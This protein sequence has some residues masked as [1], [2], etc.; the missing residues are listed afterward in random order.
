M[1]DI[2]ERCSRLCQDYTDAMNELLYIKE[3]AGDL[4]FRDDLEELVQKFME[5]KHWKRPLDTPLVELDD[6]STH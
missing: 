5:I 2:S 4:L 3:H 6:G 1:E